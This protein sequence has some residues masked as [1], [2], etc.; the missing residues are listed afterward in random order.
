MNEMYNMS[1]VTHNLSVMGVLAVIFINAMMLGLAQELKAY[2][3]KLRLFM[4]IGM[5]AIAAVIFTGI[6]M[7]TS[8]HLDFTLENIMM[9]VIGLVLI[10]L[11]NKRSSKFRALDKKQEGVF[12]SYKK[13]AFSI[14]LFEVFLIFSISAW[15]WS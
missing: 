4:P 11:E 3:R 7:M 10:I 6:V 12:S 14:L 15:M 8:Q 13:E 2:A 5:I 9:I 1:I